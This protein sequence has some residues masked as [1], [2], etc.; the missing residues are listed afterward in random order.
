M[1]L[2]RIA[3]YSRD[4]I[5]NSVTVL[6]HKMVRLGYSDRQVE[7]RLEHHTAGYEP[8]GSMARWTDERWSVGTDVDG[9]YH[10]ICYLTFERALA[11]Y[12]ARK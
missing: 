8:A 1:H 6:S 4:L 12:N 11:A 2:P 9:A 10:G 5:M 7:L 3:E